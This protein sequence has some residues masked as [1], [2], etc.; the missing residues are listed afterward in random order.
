[1]LRP[2]PYLSKKLSR[3]LPTKDGGVLRTVKDARIYMMA[4]S[5]HTDYEPIAGQYDKFVELT[6][7]GF[8]GFLPW[9]LRGIG[10]VRAVRCG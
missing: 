8:G 1:M 2:A 6:E 3:P 7:Y 4:L 10:A 9:L 5:K